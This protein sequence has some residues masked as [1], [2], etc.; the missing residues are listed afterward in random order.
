MDLPREGTFVGR[1]WRE[2]VGPCV[3]VVRGGE[4]FDITARGGQ[5]CPSCWRWPIRWR[6]CGRGGGTAGR[7][8]ALAR[9]VRPAGGEGLRRDL[10]A[11][12]DRAGDRGAG[13][14]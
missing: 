1:V 4:V 3:V 13:G 5:R 8:S 6:L 11:V 14:G 10:C 9:A 7:R 12:D 2:G